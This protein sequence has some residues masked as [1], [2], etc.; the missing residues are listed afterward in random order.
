MIGITCLVLLVVGG[1]GA[2]VVAKRV[3]S[4]DLQDGMR[5]LV[6]CA[7]S[8]VVLMLLIQG[9]VAGGYGN[10]IAKLETAQQELVRA[11]AEDCGRCTYAALEEVTDLQEK[12]RLFENSQ[13]IFPGLKD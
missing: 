10:D 11:R 8:C 2:S 13:W 7:V 5:F 3:D 1:I 6:A 4:S 9:C 12:I